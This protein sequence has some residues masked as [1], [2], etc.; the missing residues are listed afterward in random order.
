MLEECKLCPF[1]CKVN[2]EDG[3]LGK[4]MAGKNAKVALYQ[5]HYN[6]EPC[7][8]GKEGSGTVFFS[9]CN[10]KCVFCQNYEISSEEYGKEVSV[11]ELASIFIELQEQGANNINLVTPTPYVYQIIDAL[12]I[13]KKNGLRIP[14]LYN[15]S[16][17]EKVE[18]LKLLDGLIDIY[19]PDFKYADNELA[20][21]LSGTKDYFEVASKSM[22][23]MQRQIGRPILSQPGIMQKGMIIRHLILPNHIDNTEKVL[24]W[25]SENMNKDVYVSI[26]SQYFPCYKATKMEDLN[27]KIT[28]EEYCEV[29]NFLSLTNIENGYMQDYCEDEDEEKYVP[30]FKGNRKNE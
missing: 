22:I 12:K 16:G 7:I 21:K 30:D 25:I 28:Y 27:R 2:R 5:L 29:E 13:A 17:Y 10:L 26:M 1:E 20:L 23:E 9:N 14:I 8:S 11:Q 4:C 6:E 18:T 24:S 19:L 3:K 15:T